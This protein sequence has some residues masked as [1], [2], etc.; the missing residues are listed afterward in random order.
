MAIHTVSSGDT[1][2]RLS[3]V[4]SVPVSSLMHVNG[5]VSNALVPGLNLYIPDQMPPERFYQVKAG[6]TFW[7]LSQQ[8]RTS[9]QAIITANPGVDPNA[10]RI[11][12][13]IRIPTWQKYIM[14]TLVFIDAIE[15]SPYID[16]L[17]ELSGNITYLAIFTYS[18]N[19]EG[20]LIEANDE[21]IIQASKKNNIQPLMVVSNY[22]KGTFSAELADQIL[23]PSVRRTLIKNI[24][25][26]VDNKGYAG[27]SIDFEF[28]PPTR[29]ND[30]TAFLRELKLELGKRILQINAHAK[31]SDAP[32]NRLTGFLNYSAIGKVVDIMSV[33]TIDYGYAIG[34]PN[35]VSPVWWVEQVL[36]YATGQVNRRKIMMAINL[37]GYD[38]TMP[39]EPSEDARMI[40]V[41]NAQNQA[42][43]KWIPIHFD[44]QAQA[45]GYRYS[46][47]GSEHVVWFEDIRSVTAK[48]KLMEV[49]NLLG[50]TYWR[51]R[52]KFPQNW[53]YVAK[54]IQVNK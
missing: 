13:R 31:T 48:Y 35:P 25:A 51:L 32:T 23:N 38:W 26:A 43:S 41:N 2:W 3:R 7:R 28:V 37:Y 19:R 45:P 20:T 12:Q 50:T 6:D 36:K 52:F 8:F 15:P 11:G 34:P 17:R 53:A 30:F 10:L 33:M 29:R 40:A 39:D 1:L 42:I 46:E 27:V 5:L 16:L 24:I 14:Q 18:F 21:A 54:N 44:W 22:E 4:Y 49:Y 47:G 9:V